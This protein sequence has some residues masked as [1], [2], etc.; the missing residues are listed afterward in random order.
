MGGWCCPRP[1]L[2]AI[3]LVRDSIFGVLLGKGE[4]GF[5]FALFVFVAYLIGV[6]S[7]AIYIG[8]GHWAEGGGD[9]GR[10]AEAACAA[11]QKLERQM[12]I[13]MYLL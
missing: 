9:R 12:G 10:A 11:S 4:F 13:D 6:Q 8:P 2:R 7:M 1:I 3:L 5:R